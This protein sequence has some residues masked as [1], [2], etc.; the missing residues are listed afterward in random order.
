MLTWVLMVSSDLQGKHLSAL[1][2]PALAPVSTVSYHLPGIL[3]G[4]PGHKEARVD[5][6]AC[7]TLSSFVPWGP[8][9]DA[10]VQPSLE[11]YLHSLSRELQCLPLLPLQS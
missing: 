5:Q 10:D 11:A 4:T 6:E 2:P 1:P 9:I 3:L 8:R 7:E